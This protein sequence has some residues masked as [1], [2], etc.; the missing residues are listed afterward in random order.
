MTDQEILE[1]AQKLRTGYKLKTTLRYNTE[2]DFSVHSESVAEH[3]FALIFLSQYFLPIEDPESKL[4]EKKIYKMILFHDFAEIV[5]G[6][7]PYHIKTIADEEREKE[8]G[9]K[10]FSELPTIMQ[11]S[12]KD[13]WKE[14]EKKEIPE[15]R[16]VNA[17]D[18]IEPLFELLDP[19]NEKSF[20]RLEFS[21]EVHLKKK[22]VATEGFPIMR[23][24]VEAISGDMLKR[25]VFWEE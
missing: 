6:D 22:L 11:E 3:I 16:F 17:L 9:E 20:K 25:K 2:R 23:R 18:K 12:S 4:D 10:I 19:V 1:T 13:L 14:Y 5:H 15:A 21:Y 24:F 8:A 7:L